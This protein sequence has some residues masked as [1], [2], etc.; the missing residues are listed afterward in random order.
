MLWIIRGAY[1]PV[2]LSSKIS[3]TSSGGITL[4]SSIL[5]TAA[6]ISGL[7]SSMETLGS[8]ILSYRTSHMP[9]SPSQRRMY[10]SSGI[11]K[12]S[13]RSGRSRLMNQGTYSEKCSLD[14]VTK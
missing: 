14:S 9:I 3:S 13:I 2:R 1:S 11:L 12:R 10:S 5:W 8:A 4:I 7:T 6:S